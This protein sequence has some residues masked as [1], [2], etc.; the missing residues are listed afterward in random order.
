MLDGEVLMIG[1]W[2]VKYG[3]Y[4]ESQSDTQGRWDATD[5]PICHQE[6]IHLVRCRA[7]GKQQ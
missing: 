4:M 3:A 7:K 6:Y 5:S 2:D 1:R